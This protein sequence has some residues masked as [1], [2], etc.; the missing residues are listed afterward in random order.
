ML[1]TIILQ[2]G[3]AC[4]S[5]MEYK[6]FE[7]GSLI[8]GENS[9]PDEI[10]RYSIKEEER[11]KIELSK[12]R[13]EYRKL[14]EDWYVEEYALEYCELDEDGDFVQGSNYDFAS[15]V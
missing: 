9:N 8:F 3:T 14:K 10:A 13:C 15:E 1:N 12:Y 5:K 4:L 7:K 6:K 11:A 2:K